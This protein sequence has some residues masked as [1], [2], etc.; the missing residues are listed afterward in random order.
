M[1]EMDFGK[2]KFEFGNHFLKTKKEQKYL[3]K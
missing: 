3:M 1:P 2:P